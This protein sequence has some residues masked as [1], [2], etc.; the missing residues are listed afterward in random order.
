VKKEKKMDE[1]GEDLLFTNSFISEIPFDDTPLEQRAEFRDYYNKINSNFSKGK[2]R[3]S[4]RVSDSVSDRVSENNENNNNEKKT[5][6]STSENYTYYKKSISSIDTR[7]RDTNLYPNQNHF[8]AF[9][10]KTFQHVQQIALVSTE[11]PNTDQVIRGSESSNQ[12]N[13]ISWCNEEDQGYGITYSATVQ[14]VTTG[15]VNV[16]Y[17]SHGQTIGNSLL[18]HISGSNTQGIDGYWNV[19]VTDANTFQFPWTGTIALTTVAVNLEFPTYS[20]ELTPGNYNISTLATEIQTELNLVKR[21]QGAGE[22]HYFVV[23]VSTDTDVLTFQSFILTQLANDPLTTTIGTGLITVT[24]PYHGLVTGNNVLMVGVVGFSG[25]PATTLNG[26]YTITVV[27]QNTFTYL[28]NINAVSTVVGGGNVVSTGVGAPFKFLFNTLGN[29][30]QDV[31]GFPNEDSSDSTG[32]TLAGG[33]IQTQ[34]Y[35]NLQFDITSNPGYLH[36]TT[37]SNH[38]LISSTKKTISGISVSSPGTSTTIVTTSTSHG[39]TIPTIVYIRNSN[40]VP[41]IDGNWSATPLGPTTLQINL[42]VTTSGNTGELRYGGDTVKVVGLKTLPSMVSIP[43]FPLDNTVGH[44]LDIPFNINYID[45]STISSAYLAT[46][47]ITINHPNHGFNQIRDIRG[48]NLPG[49]VNA[50]RIWTW[51]P[52]GFST[53]SITCQASTVVTDTIDIVYPSAHNLVAGGNRVLITSST[54]IPALTNIA[55]V[56]DSIINNDTVRVVYTGGLTT[57]GSCVVTTSGNVVITQT[58][59]NPSIDGLYTV[60]NVVSTTQ[61]Y[62]IP[63]DGGAS[64]VAGG[65]F[66]FIGRRNQ[67]V[68]YR[69]ISDI[70]NGNTLAGISL[71]ALN[72]IYRDITRIIDQNS[73]NIRI[74]GQ[75]ANKTILTGAGGTD[76]RIS[77]ERHG[78]QLIQANTTDGTASGKLYRSINLSGEN[79]VFLV[80]PSLQTIYNATGIKDVFA[81]ILLSEPPGNVMFNTFLSEPAIFDF[82]IP[83]LTEMEFFVYTRKG[84]L[85]DFHDLDFSFSL[86]ITEVL[87][88]NDTFN[89]SSRTNGVRAGGLIVNSSSNSS[90]SYSGKIA[91]LG[92]HI[93]N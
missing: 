75:F 72:G 55:L 13:V 58:N 18:I 53:I 64:L 59:S 16:T 61:F 69:V 6:T 40:C 79:Y 37:T 28:V 5:T 39:L 86:E 35:Q 42:P 57:P 38:F 31:S 51:Q 15:Y 63:I 44:F 91:A 68:L 66:G 23:N 62:I 65:S 56:I 84:Y 93:T 32:T 82:P 52:H 73:Y 47:R 74:E 50:I 2:G 85:Y 22:F 70:P 87:N 54:T 25:I 29:S 67:L 11:F 77:S 4:D 10:G 89:T 27:D 7:D 48:F 45:S 17:T 3:I 76:V 14:T 30:I 41:N 90:G 1:D 33:P 71:N 46:D 81:K 21:Q 20:V 34:I 19:T 49:V 60:N 83:Q 9:L 8:K 80:S 36:V 26:Q 12:N 43:Y 92:R 88:S 24:Q 78:M